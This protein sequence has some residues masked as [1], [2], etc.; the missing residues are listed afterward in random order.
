MLSRR[1]D[2][3][4]PKHIRHNIDIARFPIKARTIRRTKLMRR[5][6]FERGDD[7]RI[8]F[9][10]ILDRSHSNAAILHGKKERMLFG[11]NARIFFL[12]CKI[13]SERI[14]DFL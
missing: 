6:F 9:D 8:L 2:V 5:D 11:G 10:Q 14:P 12:L 4:V 13:R 7:L 1:I 3:L